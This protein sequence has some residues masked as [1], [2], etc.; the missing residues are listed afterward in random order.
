MTF[1]GRHVL[2]TGAGRDTGRKLA[3]AFA[4]RGAH[5]LVTARTLAAAQQTAELIQAAGGA[6]TAAVLDLS[7]PA[8]IEQLPVDHLDVLVNSGA[9][10]LDGAPTA[11]DI[12][13]TIAGA[14]T[15]T[16]LLT[17]RLLP[18]LRASN[19]PDIVNLISAAG[20]PGQHRSDAHPAFYAAK[21]AQAGYAEI[22][23]ERLRP[24]GIR[25]ISLFPPD[26]VQDGPRVAGAELTGDSVVDCV[27]F[28]VG[29]PRDCFIRAFY[30]EQRAPQ[31]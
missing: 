23:S 3:L 15:G 8:S 12:G 19:Q 22:L 10:Y 28:A 4:G 31:P 6:A 5:V 26:F 11:A 21:H 13:D 29:Q 17:E 24:E 9:R 2:V 7:D 30:F 1:K 27:L 18:L 25:V 16:V 20:E 14:A